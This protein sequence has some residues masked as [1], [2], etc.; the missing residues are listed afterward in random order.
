[1]NIQRYEVRGEAIER[2]KKER[3]EWQ[4]ARKRE[5]GDRGERKREIGVGNRVQN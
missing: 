3:E 4:K 2:E 5:E 1:M